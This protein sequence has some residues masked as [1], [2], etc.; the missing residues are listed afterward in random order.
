VVA[1]ATGLALDADR[2]SQ[3]ARTSA[4]LLWQDGGPVEPGLRFRLRQAWRSLF[5]GGG[6]IVL[7]VLSGDSD[8]LEARSEGDRRTGLPIATFLD[9]EAG[10]IAASLQAVSPAQ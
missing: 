10:Q 7:V 5:G 4:A 9:T 8:P 6:A 1:A 2:T 3:P